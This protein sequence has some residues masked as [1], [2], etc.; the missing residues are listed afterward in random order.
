MGTEPSI[1]GSDS[2]MPPRFKLVTAEVTGTDTSD[3]GSEP[4]D[5]EYT[6]CYGMTEEELKGLAQEEEDLVRDNLADFVFEAKLRQDNTPAEPVAAKAQDESVTGPAASEPWIA[7]GLL[8]SLMCC[9]TPTPTAPEP[10]EEVKPADG[11]QS[12]EDAEQA[13][14]SDETVSGCC[15]K[16]PCSYLNGRACGS[17]Q[18]ECCVRYALGGLAVGAGAGAGVGLVHLG[19]T[20]CCAACLNGAKEIVICCVSCCG[21]CINH[22]CGCGYCGVNNGQGCCS[23]WG[24]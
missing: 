9:V 24:L 13:K 3:A 14:P 6:D 4:T 23:N 18:K 10:L 2:V 17:R 5:E 8:R 15:D 19:H 12:K 7:A 21:Q 1:S 22:F 16:R 20:A 11:C